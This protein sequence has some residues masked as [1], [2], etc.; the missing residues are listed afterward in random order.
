KQ[1]VLAVKAEGPEHAYSGSPLTIKYTVTNNG[2]GPANAATLEAPLPAG[3][4]FMSATD[5]GGWQGGVVSWKLD[6][7]APK[8]SKTVS[9]TVEPGTI[10]GFEAAGTAKAACAGAAIGPL[11]VSVFGISAL[12]WTLTD[13]V[14]PVQVGGSTTYQIVVTNQGTMEATNVKLVATL[15][16]NQQFVS[17]SGLNATAN[18]DKIVIET[19]PKIAAKASVTVKVNVKCSAE[20]DTRF[21]VSMTSDQLTRPA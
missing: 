17:A 12:T 15:E 1:A 18:G 6:S 7:I 21:H 3:V 14:D 9:M 5:A 13:L 19:I 10:G 16:D 11:N 2:N 20:G 8:A 4:K